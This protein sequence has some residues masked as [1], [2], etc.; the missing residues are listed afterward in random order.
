M[1]VCVCVCQAVFGR[2]WRYWKNTEEIKCRDELLSAIDNKKFPV[3]QLGR[4][5]EVTVKCQ[6]LLEKIMSSLEKPFLVREAQQVCDRLNAVNGPASLVQQSSPAE[7]VVHTA[8]PMSPAK[9]DVRLQTPSQ[10]S[11]AKSDVT[12]VD[13]ACVVT[14]DKL[15]DKD[16]QKSAVAN[17]PAMQA[18]PSAAATNSNSDSELEISAHS[19][20]DSLESFYAHDDD[21]WHPSSKRVKTHA[22][23][24]WSDLEREMVYKGVKAHGVGHWAKIRTNF[25]TA[26]SNVDIKDQWRTMTKQGR[27]KELADLYG[28]YT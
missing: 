9:H 16:K 5:R 20:T 21:Y 8:A 10:K 25:L 14:V 2:Q 11:P 17:S 12:G 3:K 27:L 15:V 24:P 23:K 7:S 26:R 6:N 13:K 22:K 28:P 18:A 4:F 19:D 1:G